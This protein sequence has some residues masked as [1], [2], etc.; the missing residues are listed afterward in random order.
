MTAF[1]TWTDAFERANAQVLGI[2]VDSFAAA[3]E[4]Q[5]KL[6]LEFPLLS[7]FP[8]NQAGRDYGVF[9]EDFGIHNRTTVVIDRE[10][11]VRDV[12]VEARDFASHP[13]HALDMLIEMGEHPY[14]D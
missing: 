3:G 1:R 7:D 14:E 8:R 12:Y 10:R 6:G 5:S 9:N 11:V 4:F 2:S 13:I